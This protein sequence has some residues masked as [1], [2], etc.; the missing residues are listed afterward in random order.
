MLRKF[1]RNCVFLYYLKRVIILRMSA[2]QFMAALLWRHCRGKI[3]E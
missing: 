3:W 1:W 2:L